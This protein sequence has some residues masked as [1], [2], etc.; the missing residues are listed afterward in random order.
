M[1]QAQL[2]NVECHY[3]TREKSKGSKSVGFLHK[4]TEPPVLTTRPFQGFGDHGRAR[5]LASGCCRVAGGSGCS[6]GI[7]GTQR[8]PTGKPPRREETCHPPFTPSALAPSTKILAF[9]LCWFPM[10]FNTNLTKS[11]LMFHVPWA[12]RWRYLLPAY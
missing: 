9:N 11:T 5:V 6:A 2:P 8:N 4:G 7:Y 1:Y 12:L 10:S 3:D